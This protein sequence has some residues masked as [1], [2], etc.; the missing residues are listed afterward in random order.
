VRDPILNSFLERSHDEAMALAASSDLLDLEPLAGT[1][2]TR[3]V[4]HFKCRGLVCRNDAIQKAEQFAVGFRFP[5]DYLKSAPQPMR[6]LTW[7]S[8]TDIFH[9]NVLGPFI[10]VGKLAQ[11]TGLE[12]LLYQTYELITYQRVTMRED[13]ALNAAACAWARQHVEELPIDPRP[14]RWQRAGADADTKRGKP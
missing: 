2:P 1:P 9:P 6:M 3:F 12:E 5:L 11:G 8:P 10:C 14:L 13:D 4:A 7:L